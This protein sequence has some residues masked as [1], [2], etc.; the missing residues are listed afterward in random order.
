MLPGFIKA[1]SVYTC[2]CSVTKRWSHHLTLDV[3]QKRCLP[4]E[5]LLDGGGENTATE[6][7]MQIE[8]RK[9]K[10]HQQI[11]KISSSVWLTMQPNTEVHSEI[12]ITDFSV[13]PFVF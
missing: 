6:E 4:L 1:F 8:K 11:K 3:H 10:T 2:V 7:N 13:F 9:K 12:K 5:E